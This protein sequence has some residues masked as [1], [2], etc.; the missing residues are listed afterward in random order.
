MMFISLFSHYFHALFNIMLLW[1][2]VVIWQP[3][4]DLEVK[5]VYVW[6]DSGLLCNHVHSILKG[7]TEQRR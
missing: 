1:M 2:E 6:L 4:I 5:I 7:S 3:L